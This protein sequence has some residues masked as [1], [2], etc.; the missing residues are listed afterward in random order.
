LTDQTDRPDQDKVERYKKQ[1]EERKAAEAEKYKTDDPVKEILPWFIR[2]CLNANEFGDGMLFKELYRGKFLYNKAMACWMIWNGHHWEIDYMDAALAAVEGVVAEYQ[3]EFNRVDIEIKKM[4]EK[5]PALGYMKSVRKSIKSR[6][7]ALRGK[8]RRQNCLLF[9]HTTD[10]PVAIQGD[11]IDNQPWLLPCPNGVVDLKTGIFRGGRPDDYLLKACR[12]KWAGIDAPRDA[13]ESA[14]MQIYDDDA[15][16]VGFMQR[17]CGC[18]LVGAVIEHIFAVLIGKRGRNGKGSIFMGMLLHVLGQLAAPITPEMLLAQATKGSSSGPT[19]DIMSLRGLRFAFATETDE[20]ARFSAARVKWFSGGE[21]LTGRNPHD[22]Y[23][24]TF[25]PTHTLFLLTNYEPH[26][27]ADD[28]A[29]W[30][31]ILQIPHNI[32]FVNRDPK[33]PHERK[34]DL[35][36]AEKLKAQ[37]PG[38]LAW[39]VEGCLLWQ[40][41]GLDP[42]PEILAA[43]QKYR[44]REDVLL[45][46][47]DECCLTEKESTGGAS[48]LF[49]VFEVWWKINVSKHAPKQKSFGNLMGKKFEKDKI[50]GVYRYYGV[51]LK[52][53][54]QAYLDQNKAIKEIELETLIRY[55]PNQ[56]DQD[57]LI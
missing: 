4:D 37:A 1:V 53:H 49:T 51:R 39:I 5:D 38:I 22:K 15:A 16:V 33:E 26:A 29:F 48:H 24:T 6:I 21:E 42:P 57:H 55:G 28:D 7:N 25:K 18:A 56:D 12:V 47:L 30:E 13:W 8:S 54:L 14:L 31:R 23:P 45:D 9:A 41:D 2:D 3:K 27:P 19:P 50:G 36:L 40:K 44:R 43:K 20:H 34:A 35:Y 52:D 17:L 10:D 11:E 46:F 32:S